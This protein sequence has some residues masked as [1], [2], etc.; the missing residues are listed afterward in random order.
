MGVTYHFCPM[1]NECRHEE[2]VPKLLMCCD[3]I[4]YLDGYICRD[5]AVNTIHDVTDDNEYYVCLYCLYKIKI[6][7]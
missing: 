6:K 7:I 4:E 1:C 5:C 3:L 2:N